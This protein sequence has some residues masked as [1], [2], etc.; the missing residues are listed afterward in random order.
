MI[1]R[2]LSH[3]RILE[4]IGAG[5]M[6]EVFLARDMRLERDVAVKLLP[7][8][9]LSSD[10]ARSL[11]RREA[12][13]LSKLNHPNIQTVHDFDSEG[14]V[15][16]LVTEYG[17]GTTLSDRLAEGGLPPKE[18]MTLGE[19]LAAGLE[20]AH[21]R[22]IVHRDLKPSNIRILP[23]G[24]LK[25]LD[26]GLAKL[27]GPSSDSA[28]T[29]SK[30]ETQT[31]AG[32]PHY[33]APEQRAGRPA[34]ARSDIYATGLVLRE[35]LGSASSPALLRI[36]ARCLENDPSKRYQT[37]KELATAIRHAKTPSRTSWR[38][39]AA[40]A[41]LA[42]LAIAASAL[43]FRSATEP[44]TIRA[45]VAL[46]SQV[47]GSSAEDFLGEAISRTLST[48]L[49][50]IE[51]METKLPPAGFELE[52]FQGD[53]DRIA[54]TFG[55]DALVLSA[56][57]AE[58]ERF[59]LNVQ[60]VETDGRRLIW[61]GDYQGP[62][63][64]YLAMVREA[65]EELRVQLR[66]QLGAI[67]AA[68]GSSQAALSFEKGVYYSHR[69]NHRHLTEDFDAALDAFGEALQLD[70]GLSDAAAEIAWLYEFRLEQGIDAAE[71]RAQAHRWAT[72]ALEIDNENGRA[73]AVLTLLEVGRGE[74]AGAVLGNSLKAARF[75]PRFPRANVALH[76]GLSSCRLRL[77]VGERIR[78]LDPLYLYS[79]L[80]NA[81]DCLG[82]T[83]DALRINE[84]VL[85][86]EPD[87]PFGL[88]ARAGLLLKQGRLLEAAGLLERL[89]RMAVQ[90]R[91]RIDW[92]RFMTDVYIV[93]GKGVESTAALDRL[94]HT[95][96]G[97]D[98]FPYWQLASQIALEVLGRNDQRERA[99]TIL[100][101]LD[102]AGV[103][104]EYDSLHLSSDR[105]WI[106]EDPE[107]APVV[108]RARKQF[109]EVV[110]VL[111][112]ARA[113]GELPAFLEQPFDEL[114][115]DLNWAN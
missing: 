111:E 72:R 65:A 44:G 37:A 92:V 52:R 10:E 22:G 53:I 89:D 15:D 77:V 70:P 66:P 59:L 80:P 47:L 45:V 18:V 3:Y 90:G 112:D 106:L 50:Q 20:A 101:A 28:A 74:Q 51:G 75:A 115:V 96:S 102:K 98:R 83:E 26:F 2:T 97:E 29:F 33:M 43:L 73:W 78:G 67:G 38:V 107:L 5:G 71:A 99:R 64:D 104:L 1:G 93:L 61:S 12:L 4:K 58:P 114:L 14:E 82:R 57:T 7:P 95:A 81:L 85:S 41:V 68:R 100:L 16:F 6:G 108:E 31:F 60:L 30:L 42:V 27:V 88:Q 103:S 19:Q 63:T 94:L 35:M 23:D 91:I 40:V 13:T 84:E 8:G 62:P 48:Y 34:D 36:I 11:F 109:A 49:A 76:M 21:E 69:F 32:T 55:V 110:A 54:A 25:I 56:L 79:G 87:F 105:R 9:R 17:P 24:R 39:A 86:I 46:P 113:R